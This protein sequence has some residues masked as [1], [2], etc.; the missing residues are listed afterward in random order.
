ML[1]N[2]SS[3]PSTLLEV[4]LL[5][6]KVLEGCRMDIPGPTTPPSARIDYSVGPWDYP[7]CATQHLMVWS[8]RITV[9]EY[10]DWK[11]YMTRSM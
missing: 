1:G 11:L 9:E 7:T 10:S 8:A 2:Y 5:N 4:I 3:R 6:Y